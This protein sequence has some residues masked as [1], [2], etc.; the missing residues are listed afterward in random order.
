M[1]WKQCLVISLLFNIKLMMILMKK[2]FELNKYF[3]CWSFRYS[4]KEN[5]F[6]VRFHHK[7]TNTKTIKIQ[8]DLKWL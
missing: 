6:L 1:P 7:I 5:I 4:R 8:I 3:C 2:K